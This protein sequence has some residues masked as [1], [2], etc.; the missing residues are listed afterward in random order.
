MLDGFDFTFTYLND[1]VISSKTKE[2]TQRT[3]EQGFHTNTGI[4]VQG[5]GS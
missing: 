5:K 4:W 1:I 2:L 3:S